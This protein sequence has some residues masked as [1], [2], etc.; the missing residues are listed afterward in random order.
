M[1]TKKLIALTIIALLTLLVIIPTTNTTTITAQNT[2]TPITLPLLFSK[3][4]NQPKQITTEPLGTY[5]HDGENLTY[6][7]MASFAK[8]LPS[9]E[10]QFGTIQVIFNFSYGSLEDWFLANITTGNT[11]VGYFAIHNQTREVGLNSTGGL[12]HTPPASESEIVKQDNVYSFIALPTEIKAGDSIKILTFFSIENSFFPE[13]VNSTVLGRITIPTYNETGRPSSFYDNW[14]VYGTWQGTITFEDTTLQCAMGFNNF[15]E[16]NSGLS[17]TSITPESIIFED[18]FYSMHLLLMFNS[19]ASTPNIIRSLE[20]ANITSYTTTEELLLDGGTHFTYSENGYWYMNLGELNE[21]LGAVMLNS[22]SNSYFNWTLGTKVDSFVSVDFSL[23]QGI[24]IPT[25]LWNFVKDMGETWN[26]TYY[27][28]GTHTGWR[29]I[30]QNGT[31]TGSG[32]L[33]LLRF[34][35]LADGGLDVSPVNVFCLAPPWIRD[36]TV[37]SL[38]VP[39]PL[40]YPNYSM[41][42]FSL[43][44][45][46]P[47]QVILFVAPFNVSGAVTLSIGGNNYDCWKADMI[48]PMGLSNFNITQ[49]SYTLYFERSTGI[50]LRAKADMELKFPMS[51]DGGQIYYVPIGYHKTWTLSDMGGGGLPKPEALTQVNTY[52]LQNVGAGETKTLDSSFFNGVSI[53][54][55]CNETVQNINAR[56]YTLHWNKYTSI[57]G[58]AIIKLVNVSLYMGVPSPP[59]ELNATLN[60]YYTPS[61]LSS[62]GAKALDFTIYYYNESSG[63]WIPLN[64]TVDSNGRIVSANTTHLSVFALVAAPLTIWDILGPGGIL[65]LLYLL[66]QWLSP[67]MGRLLIPILAAAVII[68][69]IAVALVRYRRRKH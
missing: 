45:N 39:L 63:T 54:I 18:G 50:L 52:Y 3:A 48:L 20:D 6:A 65:L 28:E 5:V 10:P 33:N 1:R 47:D 36:G 30:Y 66:N 7:G 60:F 37:M 13:V 42:C 49:F 43:D 31:Y 26:P 19:T 14:M 22:L 51:F 12:F 17:V 29:D 69:V 25:K 21:T 34:Y 15:V 2:I 40:L 68:A 8:I 35:S 56:S 53:T 4:N 67:P 16:K 62:K 58:Y 24:S 23:Y 55:K 46:N 32:I 61:E 27:D 64:T 11:H 9:G 57:D 38:I 59:Y 44:P 41:P